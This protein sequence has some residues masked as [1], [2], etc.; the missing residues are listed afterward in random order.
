[1]CLEIF[2]KGFAQ[3]KNSE[4]I[5]RLHW[6]DQFAVYW[7]SFWQGTIPPTCRSQ[8]CW[9]L[10][11]PGRGKKTSPR[12]L[13]PICHIL[14][15]GV[16]NDVGRHP[17]WNLPPNVTCS[18]GKSRR[19]QMSPTKTMNRQLFLRF[20]RLWQVVVKD[21]VSCRSTSFMCSSCIVRVF[22]FVMFR[23][24][25]NGSEFAVRREVKEGPQQQRLRDV[26]I[27]PRSQG[28]IQSK[29]Q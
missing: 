12:H 9:L 23:P 21:I 16:P 14:L 11:E 28:P 15:P 2:P 3:Q 7:T 25:P 29:N 22:V 18:F 26:K 10:S 17:Q 4:W 6:F 19:E 13:S 27:T 1:M 20:G 24:P 8:R 5:S